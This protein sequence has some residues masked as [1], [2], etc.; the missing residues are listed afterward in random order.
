ML[1]KISNKLYT[2]NLP[3]SNKTAS[4]R[5]MTGREEKIF[6]MAVEEYKSKENESIIIDAI[7]QVIENCCVTSIDIKKLPIW[8]FEYIAL[9][10]RAKSVNN[11]SEFSVPCEECE[12]QKEITLDLNQIIPSIPKDYSN[13]VKLSDITIDSQ[14]SEVIFEMKFPTIETYSL[15][16]NSSMKIDLIVKCIDKICIG[17][18]VFYTKDLSDEEIKE[19]L[20]PLS[21]KNFAEIEKYFENLPTINKE[22]DFTCSKCSHNNHYDISEIQ[23]FFS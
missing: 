11:I 15:L 20:E 9:Q 10:L 8:D 22:I 13:I 16:K 1:P 12:T 14:P 21:L 5:E 2:I 19:F 17:E 18:D 23:D 7:V 4:I 3:I 6:L